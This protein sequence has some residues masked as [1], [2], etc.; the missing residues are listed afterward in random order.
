MDALEMVILDGPLG[1]SLDKI[2]EI[3][4]DLLLLRSVAWPM[5]ELVL[6]LQRD[7]HE[8]VSDVTRIYLR[9]L[10]DHSEPDLL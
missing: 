5:R 6:S 9:D 7:P 8:C 1:N 10:Y 2:H 4:R 3:K